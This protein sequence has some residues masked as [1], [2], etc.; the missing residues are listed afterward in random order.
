[1]DTMETVIKV[2]NWVLGAVGVVCVVCL[3]VFVACLEHLVEG[4]VVNVRIVK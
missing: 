2:V 1:M 4:D 3:E